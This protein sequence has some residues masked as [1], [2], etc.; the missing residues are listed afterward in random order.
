MLP[1][2]ERR[3]SSQ[4][5]RDKALRGAYFPLDVGKV[6]ADSAVAPSSWGRIKASFR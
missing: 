1:S 3:R 6:A 4:L 5:I 2:D